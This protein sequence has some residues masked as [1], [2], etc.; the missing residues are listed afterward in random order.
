MKTLFLILGVAS[1]T[2]GLARW[3]IVPE[4]LSNQ[5][6][7]FNQFFAAHVADST[8]QI[9]TQEVWQLYKRVILSGGNYPGWAQAIIPCAVGLIFIA[10]SYYV[11]QK[12]KGAKHEP[13][14]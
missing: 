13:S 10:T 14:A 4:L 7:H 2:Y 5:E 1:I 6:G 11:S 9:S 8:N 3:Q 12:K